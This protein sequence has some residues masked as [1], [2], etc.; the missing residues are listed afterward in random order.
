ME[1][2]IFGWGSTR[3]GTESGVS[4]KPRLGASSRKHT[5]LL[6]PPRQGTPT[7]VVVNDR[8]DVALALGAAG[9]HLGRQSLPAEVV[10]HVVQSH[11]PHGFLISVSCHS[12]EGA[13]AAESARASYA[14]LGPIFET[15]SKLRYG[16]PL[17]LVE[18]SE[19]AQ[20]VKI[21]VLVLGGVTVERVK[22][23]LEAGAAG[24]AGISIFQTARPRCHSPSECESCARN[25]F[26]DARRLRDRCER[27]GLYGTRYRRPRGICMAPSAHRP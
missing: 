8:L 10:R 5:F 23:C 25:S 11:A 9:V 26:A 15:P 18:L 3:S 20:R 24:I 16:P 27:Q 4:A 14:L 21:T 17:G 13:L 12:L 22:P 1:S 19:V 7:R 6:S 2:R